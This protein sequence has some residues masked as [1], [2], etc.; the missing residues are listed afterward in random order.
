VDLF[1]AQALALVLEGLACF[2]EEEVVVE[3]LKALKFW[4]V[5][6]NLNLVLEGLAGVEG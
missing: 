3:W 4:E 6:A 5:E 2:E 1:L